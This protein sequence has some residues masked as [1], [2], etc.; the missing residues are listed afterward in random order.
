[1]VES[2]QTVSLLFTDIK[3]P[4]IIEEK[5]EVNSSTLHIMVGLFLFIEIIITKKYHSLKCFTQRMQKP[6][7]VTYRNRKNQIQTR[8]E[9]NRV[10]SLVMPTV[11][12]NPDY[13]TECHGLYHLYTPL[14][15][16]YHLRV[17]FLTLQ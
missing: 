6:S 4:L 9:L 8:V 17:V 7:R 3:D 11:S 2:S 15:D 5:D 10:K 16:F 12:K 13:A 14:I 1:M